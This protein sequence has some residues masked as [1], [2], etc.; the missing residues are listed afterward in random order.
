MANFVTGSRTG[1]AR[2]AVQKSIE[3]SL[4][5]ENYPRTNDN[6]QAT[7]HFIDPQRKRLLMWNTIHHMFSVK[8]NGLGIATGLYGADRT[9]PRASSV[10]TLG[11][12]PVERYI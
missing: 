10:Q 11:G 5:W 2:D 9:V 7:M 12:P 4:L 6:L 8:D 1:R 3:N